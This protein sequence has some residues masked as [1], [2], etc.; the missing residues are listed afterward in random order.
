MND[1][2]RA[3]HSGAPTMTDAE[4]DALERDLATIE[5]DSPSA[6][7]PSLAVGA[8]PDGSLPL[9]SHDPPMHSLEKARSEVDAQAWAD[10]EAT[11]QTPLKVTLTLKADGVAAKLVYERGLLTG[12]A[13]RG[14]GHTGEDITGAVRLIPDVPLSIPTRTRVEIRGEIVALNGELRALNI[15][16][17]H[18][19]LETFAAAR[20][21]AAGTVRAIKSDPARCRALSFLPYSMTGAG[22]GASHWDSLERAEILGLEPQPLKMRV[23]ARAPG[24][25][26][27]A[28]RTIIEAKDKLAGCDYDTDGIVV[29][30]DRNALYEAAGH[31]TRTP[32]GA[33]AYKFAA[34][35][36]LTKL[37]SVAWQVGRSGVITPRA[38][39]SPAKIGGVT[40]TSATLHNIEHISAL[41]LRTG[42][43]IELTRAGDVIP[44]ITGARP[45]MR[46]G[47]ESPINP[48]ETCPSCGSALRFD[49]PRIKCV[50][51]DCGAQAQRAIEH[52]CGRDYMDI[53]N[54]GPETIAALIEAGML[55]TPADLYALSDRRKKIAAIDGMGEQ[56]AARLIASIE[57]SKK[58]PLSRVI[59]ALGIREIGRSAGRDIAAVATDMDT[60][61]SM[62]RDSLMQIEGIGPTMAEYLAL[63]TESEQG[64]ALVR[65]LADAGVNMIEPKRAQSAQALAR[66]G[67]AGK[68]IVVTGKLT[69]FK[70]AEIK[71]FIQSHG[72]R[73]TGSVSRKTDYLVI[74]EKPGSK[75][76]KALELGVPIINEQQ[77]IELAG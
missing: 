4:Y 69:R 48:P 75:R 12:A 72:A 5:G 59:A 56:S 52:F 31:R 15:A 24:E 54:L 37:E 53:E 57:A 46:D 3:Y 68:T 7:S 30:I 17:A 66:S 18:Q 26:E 14:D 51:P 33:I 58:R 11:E 76:A 49:P 40:I 60:V 70:R 10:G 63:F 1:A 77:L 45:E 16:R 42:D 61:M 62:S 50:A 6:D 19:G 67:I 71:A 43:T 44:A 28:I 34:D 23:D 73:A 74:G 8:R 20:N 32:N 21:F 22:A 55:R 39:L 35:S 29:R 25:L 47:S 41:D 65:S 9:V 36:V 13:T 27:M 64:R 2:R 38:N